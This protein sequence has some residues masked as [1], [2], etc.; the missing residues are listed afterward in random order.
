MHAWAGHQHWMSELHEVELIS[1][2]YKINLRHLMAQ[3]HI[4]QLVSLLTF[5][6]IN[7]VQIDNVMLLYNK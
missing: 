5:L 6:F 1:F 7:S 3:V 4:A 2:Q